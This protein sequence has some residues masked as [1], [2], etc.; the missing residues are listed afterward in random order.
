LEEVSKMFKRVMATAALALLA[1]GVVAVSGAASGEKQ[2]KNAKAFRHFEFARYDATG[3]K[4]LDASA[5]VEVGKWWTF[6]QRSK[7][8]GND[9]VYI[10]ATDDSSYAP[11]RKAGVRRYYYACF[12]G[13]GQIFARE[14][15]PGETWVFRAGGVTKV[16]SVGHVTGR[17]YH[18]DWTSH[19]GDKKVAE[20][21][22]EFPSGWVQAAT[23]KEGSSEPKKILIFKTPEAALAP[24]KPTKLIPEGRTWAHVVIPG[25]G[26]V[27]ATVDEPGQTWTVTCFGVTATAGAGTDKP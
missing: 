25:A 22:V 12:P 4:T 17:K 26:D 20:G 14:K 10:Y 23:W 1:A 9:V 3:K 16:D 8:G 13:V 19:V 7:K 18:Y 2:S 11:P 27:Y 15:Q 21:M 5:D 6:L 24:G